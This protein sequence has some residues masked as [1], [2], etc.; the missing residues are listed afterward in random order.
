MIQESTRGWAWTPLPEIVTV[1]RRTVQPDQITGDQIFVG[2]EHI[3]SNTG[4][5]AGP[6]AVEAS[7]KSNKFA[8][9][10]GD[11]LYGKL[12]PNLRKCAVSRDYGICSTD[13]I[14]LRPADPDSAEFIALQMRSPKFTQKVMRM[15]GGA[16]LPR[17]NVNDLMKLELPVPPVSEEKRLY[18]GAVLLM[19]IKNCQ[20]DLEMS[21]ESLQEAAMQQAFGLGDN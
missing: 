5:Y 16:N 19:E 6:P 1:V 11:I 15:I 13:I 14:P 21:I 18:S 8:F 10:P 3:R 7:I 2:L 20:R 4:E 12:R 17:I 9:E